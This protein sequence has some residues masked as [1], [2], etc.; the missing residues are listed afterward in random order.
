MDGFSGYHTKHDRREWREINLAISNV[1]RLSQKKTK[2]Y[3]LK[4]RDIAI[5]IIHKTKKKGRGKKILIHI[6]WYTVEYREIKEN[7]GDAA[8]FVNNRKKTK[9]GSYAFLVET[10]MHSWNYVI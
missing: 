2:P 9:V 6:P 4:R 7:A 3:K 10:I 1:I 8:V 5:V